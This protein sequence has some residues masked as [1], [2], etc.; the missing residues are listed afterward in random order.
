MTGIAV[1]TFIQNDKQ[2]PLRLGW[3]TIQNRD[4]NATAQ[5]RQTEAD[6][7]FTVHSKCMI[8]LLR[9]PFFFFQQH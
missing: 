1:Y 7:L 3:R 5:T 8:Y 6:D 9:E 4:V 2:P